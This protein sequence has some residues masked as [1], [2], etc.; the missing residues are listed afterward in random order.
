MDEFQKYSVGCTKQI[1][2]QMTCSHSFKVQKQ[3]KLNNVLFR[4]IDIHGKRNKKKNTKGTLN[5][6]FKTVLSLTKR[7]S[8]LQ[9]Y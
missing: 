9:R 6:K 3:A 2:K 5:I 7:H 8:Q 1:A 4:D